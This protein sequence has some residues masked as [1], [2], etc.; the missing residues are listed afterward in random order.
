MGILKLECMSRVCNKIFKSDHELR[1][2]IMGTEWGQGGH[3]I[4]KGL[5]K[6]LA[7]P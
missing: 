5:A 2:K 3:E 1:C 6:R 7:N 4:K